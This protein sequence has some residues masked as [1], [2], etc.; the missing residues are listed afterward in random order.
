MTDTGTI[1]ISLP[2]GGSIDGVPAGAWS[3]M[4]DADR[5]NMVSQVVGQVAQ[6]NNTVWQ[7]TKAGFHNIMSDTGNL[8]GGAGSVANSLGAT[9]VGG[10]LQTGGQWLK[11]EAPNSGYIEGDPLGDVEGGHYLKAAGDLGK[12]ILSNAPETA[13]TLA[14][15]RIPVVGP[16]VAAALSGGF[17]EGHNA[18]MRSGKAPPTTAQMGQALPDAAIDAAAG[19][20]GLGRGFGASTLGRA[21]GMGAVSALTTAGHELVNDQPLSLHDIGNAALQGAATSGAVDVPGLVGKAVDPAFTRLTTTNPRND[22][23]AQA[24]ADAL[25]AYQDTQKQIAA[26]GGDTSPTSVMNAA[27]SQLRTR[28][29]QRADDLA[30]VGVLSPDLNTAFQAS[31]HDAAVHNSV[32]AESGGIGNQTVFDDLVQASQS[33]PEI[34]PLVRG[35][36]ALDAISTGSFQKLQTGPFRSIGQAVGNMAGLHLPIVGNVGK[37][38]GGAVGGVIDNGAGLTQPQAIRQGQ[39]AQSYLGNRALPGSAIGDLLTPSQAVGNPPSPIPVNTPIPAGRQT[40]Q[41]PTQPGTMSPQLAA[42]VQQSLAAHN[43]IPNPPNMAPQGAP[44]AAPQGAPGAAPAQAQA[45]PQTAP[46]GNVGAPAESLS[47]MTVP[48]RGYGYLAN[49]NPAITVGNIHNAIDAVHPANEA[50]AL[51]AHLAAGGGIPSATARPIQAAIQ[52]ALAQQMSNGSAPQGGG[53]QGINN[54]YAYRT[55]N[56]AHTLIHASTLSSFPEFTADINTLANIRGGANRMAWLG[57]RMADIE[58]SQGPAVAQRF[59]SALLP[60]A[61]AVK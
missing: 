2:N 31:L 61:Q 41:A 4:S 6:Q 45:A 21:A 43:A 39:R 1:S 59:Y 12:N 24:Q 33:S 14:T 28:L 10:A 50:A 30:R 29:V 19:M 5:S 54:V 38:I 48:Q 56:K 9:N 44:Q 3:S 25:G 55:Q 37:R 17:S 27:K 46:A 15:S 60:L 20:T 32:L 57:S 18:G 49:G 51:K 22:P 47:A 52:A 26:S 11:K 16:A 58:Q 42:L 13:T 34:A 8:V 35:L 36:R 23:R 7:A 40:P 53:A